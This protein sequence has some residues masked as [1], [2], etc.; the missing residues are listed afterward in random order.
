MYKGIQDFS[1]REAITKFNPA[2][3][4]RRLIE[5]P[6]G[7]A[8]SRNRRPAKRANRSAFR[9][10]GIL[11]ALLLSIAL[12][13]AYS[14]QALSAPAPLRDSIPSL[15][16]LRR[17]V[18][19]NPDIYPPSLHNFATVLGGRME[20]AKSQDAAE[21]LFVELK[22]CVLDTSISTGVSVRALCLAAA[23]KLGDSFPTI[24]PSA[25][26]VKNQAP[27]EVLRLL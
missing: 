5:R 7:A 2:Q 8:I 16:Q 12:V 10:R 11:S 24:K 22:D 9:E 27:P 6:T 3:I 23:L 14:L 4:L 21:S 25:E 1:S 13:S 26:A 15:D 18:A 17:E 19:A 20:A